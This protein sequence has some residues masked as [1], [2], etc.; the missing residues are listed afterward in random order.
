MARRRRRGVGQSYHQSEAIQKVRAFDVVILGP[1][2]ILGARQIEN[3]TLRTIV[4]VGGWTTIAFN[5][6]NYLSAR[7]QK[8]SR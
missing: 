2:M 1:A 3:P 6:A 4:G 7:R 8:R 5:L